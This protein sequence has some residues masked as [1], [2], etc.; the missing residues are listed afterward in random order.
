MRLIAYLYSDEGRNK[1]GYV[2]SAVGSVLTAVFDS[3]LPSGGG[4][5]QVG[6]DFYPLNYHR[7]RGGG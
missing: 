4:Q 2:S 1:W 3:T 5:D 6:S 7:I